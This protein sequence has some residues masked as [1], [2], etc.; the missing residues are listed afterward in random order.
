MDKELK[1]VRKSELISPKLLLEKYP[2]CGLNTREIG[3]LV[4][5]GAIAGIRLEGRYSCDVLESSF[6][7]YL[8][9]MSTVPKLT[10]AVLNFNII[11]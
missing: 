1:E 9:Y 3:Y 6:L 5:C 8:K 4:S 2:N 11:D 7:S 10:I